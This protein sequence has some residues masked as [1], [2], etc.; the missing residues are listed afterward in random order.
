MSGSTATV[1]TGG[2]QA[3]APRAR[4]R[5]QQVLLA[6]GVVVALAAPMV[7]SDLTFFVTMVLSAVIV[8]GLSLL[9]GYA[10]QAS[11][12][13][14]AFMA[15]GALTVA[16]LTTRAGA[17]PLLALLA[18]PV[19]SALF[20]LVVGVPLLRLRGH[21]LAFGTLALLLI[22][23]GAMSSI[24]ALGGPFGI[25]GIP[26]FGIGAWTIDSPRQYAYLALA[27]LACV[28]LVTRNVIHSRFGRGIRALAG[29]E[30]AAESAG[31]PV[32]RAKLAVFA[33]SAAY[34]G[35]AGAVSVFFT[36]FVNPDSFPPLAS[37]SYV[38]MA[39]IGGLGTLWGGVLGAVLVSALIQGLNSLSSMPSM[40]PTAAPI[41]QYAGYAV[42]LVAALLYLPRGLAPALAAL[43][44]LRR[45]W[46]ARARS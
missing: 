17:P 33:L 42:V 20:A 9:M 12:G 40:P 25:S 14:G 3:A 26:A 34:A 1:G 38:V 6:V 4:I 28:L 44:G 5:G 32:M 10:G 19:M 36:P 41:L 46:A 24:D 21:Y 31:V 30:S 18:A 7:L 22:V 13:Q 29:S 45:N 15:V 8:T 27:C 35:L 11:L 2:V 16:L 23:T 37:F 43:P 39:V